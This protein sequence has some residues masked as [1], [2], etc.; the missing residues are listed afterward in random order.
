MSPPTTSKSSLLDEAI[1]WLVRVQS[2][3]ATADDWVELTA[4]LEASDDHAE[5]F[6]EAEALSAEIADNAGEIA[7]A[8]PRP[9]AT[10]LP[11]RPRIRRTPAW[12][13]FAGLAAA[14]AVVAVV[15]T[16]GLERAYQG[17][18]VTYRTAPGETRD[19][20]LADGSHIRLDG[21]SAVTVRLG[22]RSRRV[23]MGL[24]QASFDV[25]KDPKRPFLVNVG[26]QQVRVVGTEFNIL[27]DDRQVVVSVRRGVVEVRQP[28]L[29]PNPVAR[30]LKGDEL[31]HA[32]GDRVSQQQEVDPDA[33]FAWASGRLICQDEPLS[34]I[35]AELNRRYAVPVHV[36]AAAGAKRFSGVLM[37]GDQTRVVKTLADYLS[38]TV[39]RTDRDIALS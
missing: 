39:R 32:E 36:T 3:T 4:W 19:V 20:A 24:A 23:D 15:A 10:A 2:D 31:R 1:A 21:A 8:I 6:A 12:T 27:H 26:D 25:A 16:P 13:A 17:A 29:G 37:L 18:P 5:A 28:A 9:A 11:F 38:L 35:A 34:Q 22:W 33:A 30:L 7:A 14:A